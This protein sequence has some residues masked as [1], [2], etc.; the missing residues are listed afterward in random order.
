MQLC[1]NKA[2]S[3]ECEE[4]LKNLQGLNALIEIWYF[5]SVLLCKRT[6]LVLGQ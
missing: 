2:L 5:L 1:G 4:I 6:F 3:F